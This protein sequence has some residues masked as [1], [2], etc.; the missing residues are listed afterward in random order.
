MVVFFYSKNKIKN[1][2]PNYEETSENRLKG[3]LAPG[4][5]LGSFALGNTLRQPFT[6]DDILPGL[7][8][9][10]QQTMD[11]LGGAAR[12]VIGANISGPW[13]YSSGSVEVFDEE[14]AASLS[15]KF[16]HGTYLGVGDLTGETVDGLK[17]SGAIRHEVSFAGNILVLGRDQISEVVDNLR[18]LN[19]I[20]PSRLKSTIKN[21]PLTDY[22][23]TL[24]FDGQPVD[25]VMVYMNSEQSSAEIA[26]LPN[27]VGN[28]QVDATA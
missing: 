21:A 13:H 14:R 16:G 27:A 5:R 23:S 26:V 18:A 1:S 28:I 6:I 22:V 3:S 4:N 15:G 25:A 24:S 11:V 9:E 20:P 12:L 8:G 2:M 19:G 7:S 17:I 10:A